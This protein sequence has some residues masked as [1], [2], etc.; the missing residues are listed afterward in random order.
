[1]ARYT[2]PVCRLCRREGQKLYLKGQR[3]NGPKCAWEKK[4]YPPG[5]LGE[6]S[7]R[8]RRQSDYGIQLREK[9]KLRR[10]YGVLEKPFRRYVRRAERMDGVTSENLLRL[11]ETRLDNLVY[12]AGL[13]ASRAEA[14]QLVA[15]GHIAVNE[16]VVDRPS[17]GATPGDALGVVQKSRDIAPVAGAAAAAG[18]KAQLSWLQTDPENRTA[19]VMAMP[20]RAEIDVEVDEQTIIEFYS[21]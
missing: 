1:M 6:A 9:Q 11:L 14:R 2:G 7:L 19:T 17:F 10:I 13:A 18:G 12:R 20:D 15:H 21:R 4:Q 3:C 8:R 5:H 16:A